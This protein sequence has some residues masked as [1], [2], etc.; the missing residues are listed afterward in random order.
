ME[1]DL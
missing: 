1:E